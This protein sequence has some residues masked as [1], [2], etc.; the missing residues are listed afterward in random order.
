[1]K[2]TPGKLRWLTVHTSQDM[3]KST[4]NDATRKF[5]TIPFSSKTRFM[6]YSTAQAPGTSQLM[7]DRHS[8]PDDCA[9]SE[10]SPHTNTRHCLLVSSPAKCSL[11][12]QSAHTTSQLHKRGRPKQPVGVLA[13]RKPTF[14]LDRQAN[15]CG[16]VIHQRARTSRM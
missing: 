6:F 2:E 9:H 1:M 11:Q 13:M 10:A 8:R 15:R 14:D 7:S 4:R 5:L 3:S 16:C 12:Q